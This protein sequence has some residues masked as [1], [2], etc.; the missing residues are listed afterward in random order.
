MS[1]PFST[2]IALFVGSL[3]TVSL[4]SGFAILPVQSKSLPSVTPEIQIV[5]QSS[6]ELSQ[7]E[8]IQT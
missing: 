4:S 6:F 7:A 5:A 8:K 2:L 1:R 3:I